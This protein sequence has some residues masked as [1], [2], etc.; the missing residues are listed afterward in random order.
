[1]LADLLHE[2]PGQLNVHVLAEHR[3]THLPPG[4]SCMHRSTFDGQDISHPPPVQTCVHSMPFNKHVMLHPSSSQTCRQISA[5]HF[6]LHPPPSHLW[7]HCF[8]FDEH[9][10]L[11]PPP[12]QSCQNI[13]ETVLATQPPPVQFWVQSLTDEVQFKRHPPPKQSSLH[14]FRLVHS[15]PIQDWLSQNLEHSTSNNTLANKRANVTRFSILAEGNWKSQ[16]SLITFISW[17]LEACGQWAVC[18]IKAL[19]VTEN[20]WCWSDGE[21][22]WNVRGRGVIAW[23]TKAHDKPTDALTQIS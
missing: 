13:S 3:K 18:C 19:V 12:V 23:Q 16:N 10:M 20:G 4:Q 11:H 1:M 14:V 6:A 5:S 15:P 17:S 7:S 22:F 9:A 2:P 21:E 8:T